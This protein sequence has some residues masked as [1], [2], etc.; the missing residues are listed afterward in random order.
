M[1]P[2]SCDQALLAALT[3]RRIETIVDVIATMQAIDRA[4]PDEDGLKWFNLLY[5][6]VTEE[7]SLDIDRHEWVDERWLERLDVV[8]ARLYFDA[9]ELW[10]VDRDRCPR[11]WE[12]LFDRRYHAGI[13]RVQF[14]MAGM[15]A[16]INRDLAVAVQQA[17]EDRGL[18][19]KRGTAQKA[20]FDRVNK[21]LEEVEIRAMRRM[22][23]GL[24]GQLAEGLGRAGEVF[25]MWNVRTARDA[26]WTNGEVLW[27]M[28][29]LPELGAQ[30]LSVLDR[31]AG[32]AGRGLLLPTEL[33]FSADALRSMLDR[34]TPA[35]GPLREAPSETTLAAVPSVPPFG[36]GD[37]S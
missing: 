2:A 11:A 30:Y 31:M 8:F 3:D 14:G 1:A 4:L 12:P 22:A 17:C 13:A 19:P 23:T 32:L 10:L 18:S 9:I 6:M 33:W 37:A 29:S 24:I 5:L 21:V 7:I 25:A 28:R 36:F 15:N 16:H 34:E 20:D 35:A 27:S 26:A